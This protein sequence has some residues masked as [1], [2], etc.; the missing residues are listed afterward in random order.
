LDEALKRRHLILDVF[1]KLE[2]NSGALEIVAW[3]LCFEIHVPF[4]M[5]REEAQSEFQGD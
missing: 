1:H 3:S 2:L 5:I 4:K